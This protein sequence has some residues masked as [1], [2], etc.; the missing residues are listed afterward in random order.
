[1]LYYSHQSP[2]LTYTTEMHLPSCA[3]E[4]SKARFNDFS[5]KGFKLLG[6]T[7]LQRSPRWSNK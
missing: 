5:I 7:P 6:G 2:K 3:S 1:M 4:T